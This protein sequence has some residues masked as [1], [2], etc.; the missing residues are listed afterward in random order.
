MSWL[1]S[2]NEHASR[3]CEGTQEEQPA[4]STR[5]DIYLNRETD[6]VG[7]GVGMMDGYQCG[8]KM[9]N[10]YTMPLWGMEDDAAALDKAFEIFNINHPS[11]YKQRSLSVGDVV[12]LDRTLAYS[13]ESVGW[14][15]I[16][17]WKQP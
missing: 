11:D 8:H 5:V 7:R 6:E 10:V 2:D 14:K 12:V 16:P 4:T 9:E 17:E 15:L 3:M 1:I 13:C